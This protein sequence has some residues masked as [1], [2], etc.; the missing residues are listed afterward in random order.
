M[1]VIGTM[2]LAAGLA[3]ACPA[4]AG[5]AAKYDPR[6]AFAECDT[7]HDGVVDHEEFHR[8][9]VEIFFHADRNKDG[10]LDAA[11]L[12]ELVF[13]DDFTVD[14]K[15]RDGRVSMREFMRVRLHDFDEADT[16]AK[17]TSSITVASNAPR[18]SRRLS[19]PIV[20]SKLPSP[21]P[22]AFL[23]IRRM[24]PPSAFRPNSV[25]CGPRS[26]STRSRS[27]RSKIEP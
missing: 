8:R 9:M 4:R 13:P 2:L 22:S 27:S 3:A 12:K 14:D 19:E 10:F 20:A 5:D 7:N 21:P 18:T 6:A 15:D 24:L 1:R 17:R 25:P 11:E 16:R 23:L 26:T